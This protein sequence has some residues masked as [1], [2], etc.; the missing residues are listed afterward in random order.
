MFLHS[1]LQIDVSKTQQKINKIKDLVALSP[2]A[3]ESIFTCLAGETNT[4]KGLEQQPGH[5][6]N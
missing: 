1:L 5:R 2:V 4:N 3:P 6:R